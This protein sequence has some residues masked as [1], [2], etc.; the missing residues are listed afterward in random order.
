M[1]GNVSLKTNSAVYIIYNVSEKA[2]EAKL[3]DMVLWKISYSTFSF[4][5][6]DMSF[7]GG[8]LWKT[9][10]RKLAVTLWVGGDG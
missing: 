4:V 9:T 1:Y 5:S 10:N 7:L 3:L 2:M 8:K 6:F